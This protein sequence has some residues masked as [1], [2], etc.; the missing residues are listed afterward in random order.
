[1]YLAY[2]STG[3]NDAA[4]LVA[5]GDSRMRMLKHQFRQTAFGEHLLFSFLF[6]QV[7]DDHRG[8]DQIRCSE[9]T[10]RQLCRN[11]ITQPR[12]K[13]NFGGSAPLGALA[14]QGR[15]VFEMFG[16]Y[17]GR[18]GESQQFARMALNHF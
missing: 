11:T 15:K 16:R 3:K 6:A 5:N 17:A 13:L 12:S 14:Q 4:F 2:A 10:E 7:G 9:G 18:D 8:G 1:T